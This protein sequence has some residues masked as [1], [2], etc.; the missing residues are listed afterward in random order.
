MKL[1]K[2]NTRSL[3]TVVI[4]AAV[5]GTFFWAVIE[6]LLLSAGIGIPL[7]TGRIGFDIKVLAVY[8]EVNIGTVLGIAAGFMLFKR[9]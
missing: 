4:L 3:V 6:R 2:K 9:L 7:S 1:T 8:M 5:A